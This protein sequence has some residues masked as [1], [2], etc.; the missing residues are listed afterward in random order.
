[1]GLG[2]RCLGAGARGDASSFKARG[3]EDFDGLF[4]EMSK[5]RADALVVWPTPL[6]Q[7]ERRRL[8]DLAAEHRLPAVFPFKNY[9][10]AGGL[11]S[12]GPNPPA[13]LLLVTD[14]LVG[15]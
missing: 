7:L 4:S 10:E 1:M 6:F 5:A 11:M 9:V 12:Y 2:G 13:A 14:Y 8:S 3:R 15:E